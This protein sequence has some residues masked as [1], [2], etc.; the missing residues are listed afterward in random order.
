MNPG[1]FDAVRE[2]PAIAILKKC[3]CELRAGEVA[4]IGPVAALL[5]SCWH[6]FGHDVKQ[7]AS[8][9][10]T[11]RRLIRPGFVLNNCCTAVPY[12]VV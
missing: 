1:K 7:P 4:D 11:P 12:A 6:E 2:T 8:P 9:L 5:A 3:L 10:R